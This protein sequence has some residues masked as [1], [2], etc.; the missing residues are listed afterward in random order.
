MN[1]KRRAG[2]E[3]KSMSAEVFVPDREQQ[4]LAEPNGPP[5]CDTTE[6]AAMRL[7]AL[8]QDIAACRHVAWRQIPR[9]LRQLSFRYTEGHLYTFDLRNGRQPPAGGHR[10]MK[11]HF[12]DLE[13]VA[14]A[15]PWRSRRQFLNAAEIRLRRGEHVY[16]YADSQRLLHYAWVAAPMMES[17]P[18]ELRQKIHFDQPVA[19]LYDAYTAPTMRG[20]KLYQHCVAAILEDISDTSDVSEVVAL[21]L[22]DNAQACRVLEKTGFE[23]RHTYYC[24]SVCGVAVTRG[25]KP[26]AVDR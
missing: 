21:A 10:P 7:T 5:R 19:I 26:V 22:A 23:H 6:P 14:P 16:T 15:I 12:A 8:W 2:L 20:R 1:Q 13:M 17:C 18:T 11:D 9:R 3:E 25:S 4:S 24:T